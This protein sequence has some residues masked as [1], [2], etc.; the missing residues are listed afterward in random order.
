MT[1]LKSGVAWTVTLNQSDQLVEK[2]DRGQEYKNFVQQIQSKQHLTFTLK[3]DELLFRDREKTRLGFT[4]LQEKTLHDIAEVC[5]SNN[6][7]TH[8][9]ENKISSVII[10]YLGSLIVMMN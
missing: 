7:R 4:E 2:I 3:I 1:L 6:K 9:S 5:R 10:T 8:A